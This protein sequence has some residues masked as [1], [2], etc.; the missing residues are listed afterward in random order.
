[1]LRINAWHMAGAQLTKAANFPEA[2][3]CLPG[4]F[5]Y[6]RLATSFCSA[7]VTCWKDHERFWSLMSLIVSFLPQLSWWPQWLTSHSQNKH[8]IFPWKC[9]K[10]GQRLGSVL[11]L[12]LFSFPPKQSAPTSETDSLCDCAH[13]SPCL[14]LCELNCD[15]VFHSVRTPFLRWET[16][17]LAVFF[18][19]DHVAFGLIR[20]FQIS[21][22]TLI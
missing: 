7:A 4:I 5:T 20:I 17:L 3:T 10:C 15:V 8:E 6:A 9:N 14:R 1:M 16:C 12:F 2:P 18:S 11:I 22:L 13:S 19:D 21:L